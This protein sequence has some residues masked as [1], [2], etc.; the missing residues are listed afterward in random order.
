MCQAVIPFTAF[1]MH[2]CANVPMHQAVIQFTA[3]L[4]TLRKKGLLPPDAWKWAYFAMLA[5]VSYG[6]VR[7]ARVSIGYFAML[8]SVRHSVFVVSH[9]MVSKAYFEVGRGCPRLG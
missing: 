5:S 3:F 8:A 9:A 1:L 4:M 7:Q 2:Q 6:L